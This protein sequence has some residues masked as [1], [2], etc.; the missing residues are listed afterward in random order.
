MIINRNNENN[1]SDNISIETIS[2]YTYAI[3]DFIYYFLC[4][5][6]SDISY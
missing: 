2:I 4:S 1:N 5:I 6:V 3:L